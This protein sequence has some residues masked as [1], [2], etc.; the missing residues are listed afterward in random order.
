MPFHNLLKTLD[1]TPNNNPGLRFGFHHKLSPATRT[2]YR[3]STVPLISINLS[4][5][6]TQVRL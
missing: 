1:R 3:L 5:A 4:G 2:G 6:N